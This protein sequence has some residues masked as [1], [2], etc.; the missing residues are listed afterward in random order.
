M[1]RKLNNGHAEILKI[2]SGRVCS[3]R[4]ISELLGLSLHTTRAYYM[5]PLLREGLLIRMR[6]KN[7][8]G[9]AFVYTSA[10]PLVDQPP[11]EI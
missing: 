5:Y 10:A 3:P 1:I 9:R 8:R 6:N 2:C 7:G 4:E 11:T